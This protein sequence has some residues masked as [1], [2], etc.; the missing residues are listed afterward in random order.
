MLEAERVM[1]TILEAWGQANLAPIL[2]ALDENVVWK[3]GVSSKDNAFGFGGVYR[4]PGNV[5]AL[6]SKL[7]TQ[8]FFQRFVAREIH[9]TGEMVWGLFDVTASFVPPGGSVRNRKAIALE[10]AFFWRIRDGKIL[11]AQNFFDTASLLQ[12]QGA[13][14]TAAA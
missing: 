8:Y 14:Q 3:S 9:S 10:I 2:D 6:L 1:V 11:E 5:L 13:P 4:G 7:S 12:Q